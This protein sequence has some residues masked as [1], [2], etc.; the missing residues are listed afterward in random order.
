MGVKDG[1]QDRRQYSRDP[2]KKH[3]G[4]VTSGSPGRRHDSW[5]RWTQEITGGSQRVAEITTW[6]WRGWQKA[7]TTW[8]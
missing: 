7:E 6:A 2:R 4:T 3:P 5:A 1:D 8:P